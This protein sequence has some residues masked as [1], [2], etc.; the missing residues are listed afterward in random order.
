MKKQEFFIEE[1]S[2]GLTLIGEPIEGV[3]SAAFSFFI[4]V[5][6]VRDPDSQAGMSNLMVEMLQKGCGGKSAKEY[7]DAC[8]Q[9]GLQRGAGSGMEA[10][11]FS[12]T[13]LSENLIS[14]LKLTSDMLLRPDFPE[15]ELEPVQSLAL[16]DLMAIEDEPASKVMEILSANFYPAPFSRSS[17]GTAQG[18]SSVTVPSMRD[19][20]NSYFGA[21]GSVLAVAGKFVWKDIVASVKELFG[22]WKGGQDLITVP[23]LSDESRCVFEKKEAEQ[24][25][26]ALA[27]PSVG[28]ES[29]E[30]YDARVLVNVLSGGM[31]GRLFIEV[32]EKRGLVYRVSASHS[33]SRGRSAII[34]SAGT[35]P[36]N[37]EETLSV[38]LEQ[39]RSIENGVSQEELHRAKVDLK[40]RVIM[41]SESS[42]G[43]A[44]ALTSDW[45]NLKRLRTL[46][47]IKFGIENVTEES[48]IKHYKNW[49]VR[50]VTLVTLGVKPLSLN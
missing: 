3:S 24:L 27:Y 12:G 31:S 20:F 5:G 38:M 7:S 30:Y 18:I 29:P 43:R 15:H 19:F 42:S 23:Q 33:A 50:A 21:K 10:C 16:Q 49:P 17:L 8:E 45:W 6:A 25:Q 26:I 1:L 32:R 35:T 40:T 11:S 14:A 48:L 9:I 46:E 39:L 41:Q 13:L 47:E 22:T 28:V 37:G 34:A 44:S 4:P 36:E 2:N